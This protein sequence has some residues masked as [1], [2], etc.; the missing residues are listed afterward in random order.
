[1]KPRLLQQL[2][3][4]M[5]AG[6]LRPLD[7]A[8]TR[9][10]NQQLPNLAP[11][12][13][14]AA[15]LVSERQGHGHVCL[16][17]QA[18]LNNP[19]TLL[20]PTSS[21][22]SAALRNQLESFLSPLT[23]NDWVS[24][25]QS[26]EAVEVHWPA[27]QQE[28][29][30]RPLVLGGSPDR[31]LL[32]LRRYW[33]YEKSLEYQ[34]TQRLKKSHPLPEQTADLVQQ[35]FPPSPLTPQP[36]WQKLACILAAR[37]HF[38]IITGGPGTGKTTTVVRLLA[39]LQGL[40]LSS[41]QPFLQIRLAA[42]TGKAAAR[43]NE[44]LVK[45]LQSLQLTGEHQDQWKAS[46]PQ[47][48]TTLHRL[49]GSQPNTRKFRHHPANPLTADLVVVDEASMVDVEMM[50]NLLEALRPDARLILLGDKDQ[51]A[52]VEAG[53]ILGDLCQQAEAGCYTPA[54]AQLLQQLTGEEPRDPKTGKLLIDPQGTALNQAT[55]MLRYSFRF[56]RFQGIGDL[57]AAVNQG[58]SS[59]QELAA[60]FAQDAQRTSS[61][62][63]HLP[64]QSLQDSHFKKLIIQGYQPYLQALA[65]QPA[66]DDPDHLT[67]WALQLFEAHQAFQLLTALR[68]GD[69]GVEGLNTWVY[70]TLRSTALGQQ[71][72]T[73]EEPL[74][75]SG[76]PVL[77]TRNDYGLQ[78]MN[79]DIG[80]C[81]AL[82]AEQPGQPSRLRVAFPDPQ[83]GVR[84]VLPSRL[85]D[86]ETVF[87][88]TVHKSQ[89]SEFQH[90]ALVLPPA[91]SPLLSKELLYTAITR[92][93]QAFTLVTSNLK[94]LDQLV[95]KRIQRSSGLDLYALNPGDEQ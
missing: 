81:L 84:W 92:S 17:L 25:L 4:W 74:W 18:A 5:L 91:N 10:L 49:L 30:P 71:L 43:L 67:R 21:Q 40:Q 75:Y 45:S 65:A 77:M 41:Q 35:L 34:L 46:L 63:T 54:T 29:K 83:K 38:A 78:L 7:L 22:A 12:V 59:S 13:L 94:V 72:F 57:A 50:A 3:E 89:G 15:A 64:I 52:S 37:S 23:L 26:S 61:S 80:I 82:P 19:D 53:S 32:Y 1:M 36:D 9:F 87:A 20:G 70:Q 86:V 62:I 14:L 51:L 11:E 68:Q 31:P 33:Q 48:V 60:I 39:L 79:G 73:E 55:A 42:P 6:A 58:H 88:M 27:S 69:W 95:R 66:S 16:D 28:S 24:H 93:S 8:F 76:R 90:T 47:E 56:N 2:N 44:S 85:Q